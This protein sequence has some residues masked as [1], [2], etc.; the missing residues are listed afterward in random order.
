MFINS[1]KMLIKSKFLFLIFLICGVST[2]ENNYERLEGALSDPISCPSKCSCLGEFIDCNG[3]H[4]ID[5]PVFPS[6]V[7]EL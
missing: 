1:L 2:S 3:Q 6:W 7:K 4:F 5:V